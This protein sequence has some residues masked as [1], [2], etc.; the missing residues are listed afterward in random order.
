MPGTQSTSE[1]IEAR[2]RSTVVGRELELAAVDWL[3]EPGRGQAALVL[4]GEPGIGKTTIVRAA[5]ERA[6]SASLQ[7]FVARPTAGEM[8]LPYASLGDLLAG[9]RN[10]AL[11]AL[12]APQRDAIGSAL[13][14]QESEDSVGKH[15]LSRGVF[16]LLRVQGAAGDLLLVIDDVQ[17]LDRPT[18]AALSFALRRLDSVP[19]RVLLARRGETASVAELPLGLAEW[20]SARQVE[21]GP[22]SAT[23]LGALI[24]EG[25]DEQWSRPRLEWLSEISG[26]NPMFALE[27]ARRGLHGHE[28][29]A[30]QSLPAALRDRLGQLDPAAQEILTGM[31]A[32]LRPTPDIL[33]ASGFDATALKAALSAGIVELAE[34]RLSFTH[35]LLGAAAYE[36]TLPD[37][38]RAVH[39]RL[40]AAASDP[41]EQGHHVSRSAIAPDDDAAATLERAAGQAANLGDHGG[42][43]AFLLRAAELAADPES[44]VANGRRLRAASEL[45]LAGDIE[46]AVDVCR[47]LRSRLPPGPLR[48]QVRKLQSYCLTG[49]AMS[50]GEAIHELR[51]GLDEALGDDEL[52][53]ELHI[54]IAEIAC[55]MCLLGEAVSH[56]RQ[57][58]ELAEAIGA[59]DASTAALCGL[60][61]AESMLGFGVS[62]AARDAFARWDGTIAGAAS[63]A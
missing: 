19:V 56:A 7:V 5:L 33:F 39:L 40:A 48:A 11:G 49:S 34:G 45:Y 2:T 50:Y 29:P 26:G 42:A 17:W 36:L 46:A 9:V 52:M 14:R 41:V 60:G 25:L 47:N 4:S 43:A 28:L 55:G 35:P 6:A 22:L 20:P 23:D 32:C 31:A 44:E 18:E 37:E 16:E 58:I 13:G 53:A 54:D 27:L 12:A 15:A 30:L 63:P 57:A 62:S 38:R 1:V 10:E 24:R 3:L 59:V 21:I 61:F 8:D 51:A